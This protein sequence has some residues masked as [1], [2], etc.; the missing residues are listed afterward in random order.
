[1]P[2]A[3]ILYSAADRKKADPEWIG[4]F[5]VLLLFVKTRQREEKEEGLSSLCPP[6]CHR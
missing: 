4:F 1:M 6:G 5:A 2:V 3:A